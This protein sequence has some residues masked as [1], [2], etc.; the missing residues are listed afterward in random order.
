[1]A[2]LSA[3]ATV[4]DVVILDED[5]DDDPRQEPV[6]AQPRERERGGPFQTC[7]RASAHVTGRRIRCRPRRR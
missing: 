3:P 5:K 7:D 1:M 2:A 4:D 6:R